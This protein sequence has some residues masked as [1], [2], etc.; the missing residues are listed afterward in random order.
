MV[1][2][3]EI[4]A[5][6]REIKAEKREIKADEREIKAEKREIKADE[7]EIKAEKREI[8]AE[9]REI[10]VEEDKKPLQRKKAKEV[11]QWD[12][13][14]HERELGQIKQHINRAKRARGLPDPN[15]R[16]ASQRTT[17][18][19][20]RPNIP[21]PEKEEKHV[22]AEKILKKLSER[23]RMLL[24]KKQMKEHQDRMARG[25]E[26][27]RQRNEEKAAQKLENQPVPLYQKPPAQRA[28]GKELEWTTAYPLLQ[29]S[30]KQLLQV[31]VL[32]EKS[33][34]KRSS[35]HRRVF[36]SMPPFLRSQI[37]KIKV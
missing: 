28:R 37:D 23:N 32:M 13:V 33:E 4:K 36:L 25:R 7:R 3:K 16:L 19:V 20:C 14:V 8:K 11:K 34:E 17:K 1:P 15:Y 26:L 27:T 18:D 29:P 21:S 24:A 35:P 10:K 22:T 30:Q 5:E 2:K 31:S 9:K 6:E 12:Y